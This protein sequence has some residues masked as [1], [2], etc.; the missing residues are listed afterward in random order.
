VSITVEGNDDMC[1]C[2]TGLSVGEELFYR[3]EGV[4]NGIGVAGIIFAI[5]VMENVRHERFAYCADVYKRLSDGNGADGV[6]DSCTGEL[7]KAVSV[8]QD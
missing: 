2:W 1:S 5:T 8:K 6:W 7:H 4:R 3:R